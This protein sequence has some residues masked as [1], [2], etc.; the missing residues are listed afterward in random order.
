[1]V[2]SYIALMIWFSMNTIFL[3][4]MMTD[5]DYRSGRMFSSYVSNHGTLRRGILKEL[6]L[7][8][9]LPFPYIALC[10]KATKHSRKEK[11]AEQKEELKNA[12]RLYRCTQC[13][14]M[15]RSYQLDVLEAKEEYSRSRL[16]CRYCNEGKLITLVQ[17]ELGE[18]VV[19]FLKNHPECPEIDY[20]GYE[21]SLEL[22]K[23]YDLEHENN[24]SN[25]EIQKI[26]ESYQETG[27]VFFNKLT[28][29][30]EK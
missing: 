3:T 29:K 27:N 10:I 11:K 13:D 4:L 17:A 18:T 21:K 7:G 9:L 1:M 30:E 2:G 19:E 15:I 24:K 26:L 8:L 12:N 5:R 28:D 14:K 23:S 22:V 25:K 20:T 6:P 16:D